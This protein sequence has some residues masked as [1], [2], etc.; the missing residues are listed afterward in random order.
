MDKERRLLK[1][2]H[3]IFYLRVFD[4][5]NNKLLGH[6]VDITAQ[7]MMLISEK[8]CEVNATYELKMALPTKMGQMKSFTFKAKSLWCDKDINPDFYDTGYQILDLDL[9]AVKI[10][11][12]LISDFGFRD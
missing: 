10:I 2:R 4:S 3:L 7:G 8:P 5:K 11:E 1:R 9:E 12:E 6:L